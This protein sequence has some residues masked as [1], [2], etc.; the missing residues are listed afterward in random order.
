MFKI[1]GGCFKLM[2]EFILD[3][4]WRWCELQYL[5]C[6]VLWHTV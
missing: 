2:I 6:L 1:T 3:N 5:V 4:R